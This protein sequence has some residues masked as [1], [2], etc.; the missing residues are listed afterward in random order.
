[1]GKDTIVVVDVPHHAVP[2]PVGGHRELDGHERIEHVVEDRRVALEHGLELLRIQDPAEE[3]V[4]HDPLIVPNDEI[5]R[6][7]EHGSTDRCVA[8]KCAGLGPRHDLV[9]EL[10][11]RQ[12][13][14]G[15]DQVLV[16][17]RITDDREAAR[18]PRQVVPERRLVSQR[19]VALNFAGCR[20]ANLEKVRVLRGAPVEVGLNPRTG[21]IEVVEIQ[22]RSP[23]IVER[24][25]IDD[26]LLERRWVED[27]V[28]IDELA[29]VGKAGGDRLVVALG[30]LVLFEHRHA[31]GQ[32]RVI[33]GLQWWKIEHP[34]EFARRGPGPRG[35]SSPR[36]A[37]RPWTTGRVSSGMTDL[38]G[39][40]DL[41][42]GPRPVTW[43]VCRRCLVA[44]HANGSG[45]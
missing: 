29:E 23:E 38:P 44:S 37:I 18:C 34:T 13:Q 32:Q 12:M 27:D 2:E 21:A 7:V 11:E 31:Q 33:R 5:T 16:V 43:P 41:T 6:L 26:R 14:L 19:R 24:Q 8:L 17:A 10:H 28:V 20:H 35:M 40:H 45:G 1:L 39:L 36:R 4:E 9:V 22:R 25:R 3:V 30:G 42:V 15:D